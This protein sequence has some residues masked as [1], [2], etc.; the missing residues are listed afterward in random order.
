MFGIYL[1]HD[2]IIVRNHIYKILKIDNGLFYGH[3]IFIR[4]LLV[5]LIIFISCLM[6]ELIRIIISKLILKTK[7]VKI[8]KEKFKIFINSFNFNT[9]W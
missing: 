3:S 6:I 5:A 9:N 2:N 7:P 4:I 8:L 1:I